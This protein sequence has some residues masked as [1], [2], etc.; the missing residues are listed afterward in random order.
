MNNKIKLAT[1]GTRY[2]VGLRLKLL[3]NA[4]E[5]GCVHLVAECLQQNQVTE[6]MFKNANLLVLAAKLGYTDICQLLMTEFPVFN[7]TGIKKWRC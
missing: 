4:V 1:L 3:R 2:S 5:S 7:A 6:K